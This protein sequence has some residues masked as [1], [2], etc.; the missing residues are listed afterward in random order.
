MIDPVVAAF[1]QLFKW[2]IQHFADVRQAENTHGRQVYLLPVR[3]G[4]YMFSMMLSMEGKSSFLKK[5]KITSF[6]GK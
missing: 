1:L 6:F 4:K 5:S 3:K 2:T